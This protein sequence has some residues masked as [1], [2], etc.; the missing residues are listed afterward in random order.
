MIALDKKERQVDKRKA[1]TVIIILLILFA[2]LVIFNIIAE[3]GILSRISTP[4]DEQTKVPIFLFNPDYELNIF[5][6][7]AYLDLDRY[8]LY[9]DDGIS[10]VKLVNER[11]FQEAGKRAAFFGNYFDSI[12]NGDCQKYNE[13]FTEDYLKEKGKKDRFT[14]QM[15]YNIEVTLLRE[16]TVNEGTPEQATLYEFEV[17]YAI[18]RNNGT[19]RDDLESG[20]TKP[21]IYVL[22]ENDSTEEILI[23]SITDVIYDVIYK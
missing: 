18:R 10:F 1:K 20:V 17:R 6:D 13:F 4:D 14:M 9:S 7:E 23:S 2:I 16:E 5:E 22:I 21:Q 11:A 19:F 15:L 3:S 8:I 12:I